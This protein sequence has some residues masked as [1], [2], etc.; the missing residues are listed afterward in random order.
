MFSLYCDVQKKHGLSFDE[1]LRQNNDFS[2]VLRDFINRNEK[3]KSLEC[4][5]YV[6]EVD[7]NNNPIYRRTW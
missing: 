6:L 4:M 3:D 5:G 2:S 1:I 7:E